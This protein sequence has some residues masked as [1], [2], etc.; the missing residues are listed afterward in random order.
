[1][2]IRRHVAVR[3]Q[4]LRLARDEHQLQEQERDIELVNLVAATTHFEE[5]PGR[6]KIVR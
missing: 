6:T 4:R 5:D 3:S 2:S 1:M